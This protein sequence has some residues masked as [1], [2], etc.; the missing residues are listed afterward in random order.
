MIQSNPTYRHTLLVNVS[1]GFEMTFGP[2]PMTYFVNYSMVCGF[3]Q[4]DIGTNMVVISGFDSALHSH[5]L[6]TEIWDPTCYP[7][8]CTWK[9]GSTESIIE[10]IN[11]LINLILSNYV[12]D[13]IPTKRSIDL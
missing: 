13:Y 7:L 4:N 6:V 12:F 10:Y 8:A 1:N 3:F 9:I 5:E 2:P 11:Q